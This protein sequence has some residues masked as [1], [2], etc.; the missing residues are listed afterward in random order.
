MSYCRRRK[1]R[2][3]RYTI[4]FVSP[5]LY[6]FADTHGTQKEEKEAK[7]VGLLISSAWLSDSSRQQ[8]LERKE[9][10]AKAKKLRAEAAASKSD[11]SSTDSATPTETTPAVSTS[12]PPTPALTPDATSE[13]ST[14]SSSESETSTGVDADTEESVTSEEETDKAEGATKGEKWVTVKGQAPSTP[15]TPSS[16]I[17]S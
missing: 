9:R 3:K 16:D 1:R 15:A 13:S 8:K 17:S 2:P 10:A 4:V 12:T 11:D 7:E 5:A 14:S 6:R